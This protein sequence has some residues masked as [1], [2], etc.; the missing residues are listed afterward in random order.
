MSKVTLQNKTEIEFT[1][2]DTMEVVKIGENK[3]EVKV[4]SE[5]PKTMKKSDL[6]P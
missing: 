4:K 2:P 6:K 1:C 5:L 3:F